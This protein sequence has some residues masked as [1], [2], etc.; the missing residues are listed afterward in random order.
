MKKKEAVTVCIT[1]PVMT[2]IDRYRDLKEMVDP[3]PN[4]ESTFFIN[5]NKKELAE[6]DSL[7]DK[8]ENVTGVT[9]ANVTSIR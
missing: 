7:W 3:D 9:K 1:P 2:W 4:R 8:F 5:Y 6:S